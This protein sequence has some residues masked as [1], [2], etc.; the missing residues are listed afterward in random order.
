MGTRTKR[1]EEEKRSFSF[2]E[3]LLY[4]WKVEFRPNFWSIIVLKYLVMIISEKF[5]RGLLHMILEQVRMDL[6]RACRE[7]DDDSVVVFFAME[8]SIVRAIVASL[9]VEP[10]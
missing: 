6:N 2:V 9:I 7:N 10:M 3:L 1:L 4:G 5:V 8:H